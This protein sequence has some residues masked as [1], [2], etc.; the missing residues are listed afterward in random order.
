MKQLTN[1]LECTIIAV[2]LILSSCS[3]GSSNKKETE[4]K[5][6]DTPKS[7]IREVAFDSAKAD[8]KR[9]GDFWRSQQGSQGYIN[10]VTRA[11]KIPA[12][13]LIAVLKP[14]GSINTILSEC[15]YHHARA[16]LGLDVNNT[17]HLYFTPVEDNGTE[18]GKDVILTN[19]N[20]KIVFDLTSPCPNTC[21]ASS[22]LY[23]AF[24]Q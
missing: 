8:I 6:A 14:S 3:N 2:V 11:F 18:A 15:T 1:T 9:Y 16:Y 24:D 13:D 10:E 7:V 19:G 22:P 23:Q 4:V 20:E 12:A 17:I 21:D 5:A